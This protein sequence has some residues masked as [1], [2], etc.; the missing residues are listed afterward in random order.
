MKI[1]CQSASALGTDP[2]LKPYEE[3]LQ[4]HIQETA[5]RGTTV[6]LHGVKVWSSAVNWL[7]YAEYLNSSEIIDNAIEAEKKGYDAFVVL[8]MDDPAFYEL[9]QTVNI[10]VVSSGEAAFHIACLL[11]P[12]F[13]ILSYNVAPLRHQM[14][15]AK[16][17]GLGERLVPGGAFGITLSEVVQ[18]FKKPEPILKGV[19]EV[20]KRASEQGAA[21]LV[22]SCGMLNMILVENKIRDVEG[23]PILD[24]VGTVLKM[25]ELLVDLKALGTNRSN[26]GSYTRV[27]ADELVALRKAYGVK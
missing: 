24:T 22:P 17:Y 18:S 8:C 16:H 19:R 23:V 4:K 14:D 2:M 10:P 6:H 21:I 15:N 12:K 9:R 3:A 26:I 5:R 25:A 13:A 20:S 11:A 7:R 1:W 27:A